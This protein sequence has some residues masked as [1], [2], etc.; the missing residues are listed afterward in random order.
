MGFQGQ[1]GSM[2]LADLFQSFLANRQTGTL[3]VNTRES[4]IRIFFDAGQIAIATARPVEGMPYLLA[5][6]IR[7][8]LLTLPKA[9]DLKER[10]LVT[11]QPL[12]DL[13]LGSGLIAEQELDDLS[14]WCIEEIVCPLFEADDGE[15]SFEDGDPPQELFAGDLIEMGEARVPTPQLIMEATRRKDE[16]ERIRAVIPRDDLLFLVDNDGRSNLREIQTDPEMMKVLRYLD[17]RH[18]LDDIA[19]TIGATRFDVF[20]I[21]AQM[22]VANV[23]RPRSTQEVVQDAMTMR[24]AGEL[25]KAKDLLESALQHSRQPEVMRPLAEICGE[26]N[27][28]ARAVEL[29]L[30]LIQVGKDAGELDAALED[31]N[32]VI[33]LS[34]EDPEL[35]FERAQ[36]L[37]ELGRDEESSIG[38]VAA[39]QA[40]LS[41]RDVQRAIDACHRAKNI[42]PRDPAPHRWLAKAYQ[43]DGQTDNAAVEYKALWHALLTSARP[44]AALA[45]LERTLKS[46]CK[47]AAITEQILTYARSSE[48]VKTSR[49]IQMLMYTL[50]A[51]AIVGC[52]SAGY[53]YYKQVVVHEQGSRVVS[54][55]TSSLVRRMAAGE[56]Q[57]LTE[58]LDQ[59]RSRY[60]LDSG[61]LGDINR[62]ATEVRKNFADRATGLQLKGRALMDGGDFTGAERAILSLKRDFAGTPASANADGLLEEIRQARINA[63]IQA[64]VAEAN[65]RWQAL[66]WDG[67]LAE[68]DKILAR[69]DL[70][71]TRRAQLTADQLRWAAANRSAQS[72]LERAGRI[73]AIGDLRAAL[74]AY[75]KAVAGEGD[76]AL[77]KARD[78][79]VGVERKLAESIAGSVVALATKKDDAGT[80]AALDELVR[81]G[82]ESKSPAVAEVLNA[83][84]IPLS[85]KVDSPYTVLAIR[86]VG[87][88]LE[89]LAR[90]PGNNGPWI[91][92]LSL[93]YGES[94]QIAASRVGF[95]NQSAMISTALRKVAFA[96][97]LV[98]GP[99]WKTDL[100]GPATTPP[101]LSGREVVV[102]TGRATLEIVDARTGSSRPV[103]FPDTVAEFRTAPVI[104]QDRA[105]VVLEDT[106][107]VVD[108]PSRVRLWSWTGDG[109]RRPTGPV[110][111]QEHD[112]IPGQTLL[113]VATFRAGPLL[114]AADGRGKVSVYPRLKLEGD[115]TGQPF[116]DHSGTRTALYL[117]L[118]NDLNVLDTTAATE[119]SPP[120]PIY[121]MRFHGDL[122]G[123]PVKANVANGRQALLFTDSTGSIVAVDANLDS[124]LPNRLLGTW[125]VEGSGLG[126]PVVDGNTAYV[127]SADGR[128]T[129]LDLSHPG[130][131]LWRFPTKGTAGANPGEVGIG[132]RGIYLTSSSGILLCVDRISGRERW[133]CDLGSSAVGGVA[134]RDGLI[135]VALT[136]GQLWCFDE[137]ED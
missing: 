34:P 64:P 50:T 2:Q 36:L 56:H 48:A 120:T 83:L 71:Y 127:T 31:L 69:N 51:A 94:I 111:A 112:L 74:A 72:L 67:A 86:R 91:Q 96:V 62:A 108:I 32:T 84:E 95:T 21:V 29:Y 26:L 82:Q 123:H 6:M 23:A 8:G 132:K 125:P 4:T 98:R 42:L 87:S 63:Q 104:F 110:W 78:R 12:R 135:F 77:S 115:L 7:K 85:I 45:E 22:V 129:A 119:T 17:G 126:S 57:K 39:A 92:N 105:Y 117:P 109:D 13:V 99:R 54:D 100:S 18:T 20:A 136:S 25:Q 5:T 103:T 128:L 75:R 118:G 134:A 122:A 27:Q 14:A 46:D 124:P 60:S 11:H 37:S 28:A 80:F 106:L 81:L 19:K 38:F 97:N 58:E 44:T 130:Q 35:H 89:Q 102:G 137:G 49:A 33:G 53:Y 1:L 15:L 30:E 41:T 66:D 76:A 61:L 3:T 10:L 131:V 88:G 68:L 24:D 93:H 114:L 107:H 121:T 55:L 65:R 47:F 70:P 43:L 59:L 16:W 101:V 113:F 73:E 90:A 9:N 40:F 116:A 79:M 52:V 133:R